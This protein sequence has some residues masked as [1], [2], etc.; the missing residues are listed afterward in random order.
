M[1]LKGL[2]LQDWRCPLRGGDWLQA[3]IRVAQ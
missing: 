3:G 2:W 1:P